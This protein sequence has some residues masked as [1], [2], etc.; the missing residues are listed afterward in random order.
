MFSCFASSS[1]S[2]LGLCRVPDVLHRRLVRVSISCIIWVAERLYL[3]K[4]SLIMNSSLADW[5][6]S[7]ELFLQT[8][9]SLLLEDPRRSSIL[10]A[11]DL[12][13]LGCQLVFCVLETVNCVSLSK[14]TASHMRLFFFFYVLKIILRLRRD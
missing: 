12:F 4:P 5:V 6:Y 7:P 8:I 3:G 9:R 1:P 14:A 11:S 10:T 2:V 13:Q